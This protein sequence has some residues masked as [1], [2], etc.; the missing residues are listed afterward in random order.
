M[1]SDDSLENVIRHD[2]IVHHPLGGGSYVFQHNFVQYVGSLLGKKN[3]AVSIGAQPNSAPHFGTLIVFNLAFAL[4]ERL[5]SRANKEPTVLFE[6]VDTAPAE[7]VIIDGVQYQKSLR[8]THQSDTNIQFYDDLLQRLGK[9]TSLTYTRR[10]QSEFSQTDSVKKAVAHVFNNRDLVANALDPIDKR[11]HVRVACENCG[12]TDK[13][14]NQTRISEMGVESF[15]PTHGPYVAPLSVASERYEYNTPLRNL[16]R[17][18]AYSIDN[19]N[20]QNSTETLRVTGSD[21]AG[22]YQEQLLYR[23]ASQIGYPMHLLPLIVYAPLVLDWSGA[24]LSKSLY[25]KEGAYKDLP[26]F[27]ITYDHFIT[28]KGEKGMRKLFDE[29]VTWLD[30]PYRLFRHYSA[31]YFMKLL[32]NE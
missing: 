7:T 23:T 13:K 26:K 19:Q 17:A 28:E 24:K 29:V 9:L 22:F 18:I 31:Y 27:L 1:Q 20:P 4:A 32:Q 8:T 15:C 6:I 11:L 30:E 3:I 14:G 25:V 5:K 21:Y 12:L 10:L 16:I 2:G